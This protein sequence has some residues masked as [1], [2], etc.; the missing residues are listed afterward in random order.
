MRLGSFNI[1]HLDYVELHPDDVNKF[2][3][4]KNVPEGMYRVFLSPDIKSMHIIWAAL[5]DKDISW[6]HE[7]A[8]YESYKNLT[9]MLE[10][11]LFD[12]SWDSGDELDWDAMYE[13]LSDWGDYSSA[14]PPQMMKIKDI[15]K[16]RT[17]LLNELGV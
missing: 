1:K 6:S 14:N 10:E 16:S 5:E 8:D 13:L 17:Q 9:A 11:E 2:A 7:I 12:D 15:V 3:K 4:E